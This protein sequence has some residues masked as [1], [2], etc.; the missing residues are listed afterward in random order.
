[1]TMPL[2]V[3]AL[4]AV[5]SGFTLFT[6]VWLGHNQTLPNWLAPSVGL[7]SPEQ[8][9]ET[10]LTLVAALQGHAVEEGH[11]EEAGHGEAAAGH[12]EGAHH[13]PF[14]LIGDHTT[15]ELI[16]AASSVV[17][18]AIMLLFS[19]NLYKNKYGTTQAWKRSFRPLY[20]FSLN[21]WYIDEL[22]NNLL[23]RPGVWLSYAFW[24][25][26]D[27]KVIDGFVN[28]TAWFVGALGQIIRP[29]QTGFVRNYA[30]Y[31]LLGAVLFVLYNM[32]R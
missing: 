4:F 20:E 29:L 18:A 7:E 13:E 28:G 3:L 6:P 30:L 22:Y 15:T 25:V 9:A 8:H 21:K 23:V 17:L 16:F 31:L 1:M 10:E 26:F 19:L 27:V 11:A 12:S 5:I 2:V 24:R 32:W 14:V